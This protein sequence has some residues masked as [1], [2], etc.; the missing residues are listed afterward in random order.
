LTIGI[1]IVLYNPDLS[2]LIESI[3]SL[4]EQDCKIYL[5]DNNSEINSFEKIRNEFKEKRNNINYTYL[6][7][8]Y[9]IAFAMNRIFDYFLND[10]EVEWVMTLDQD[11][12]CPNNICEQYTS[13]I[14][15][16][17]VGIICPII[18]NR[19]LNNTVSKSEVGYTYVNQCISSASLINKNVWNKVGGF[20]ELMFI[21]FVDFDFCFSIREYGYRIVR[22]NNVVLSHQLGNLSQKKFFNV[23]INVTN[24]NA[25]RRFYYARN[26]IYC[27]R[28]H[29]EMF[30]YSKFLNK[31]I[32]VYLKVILFENNKL[33]KLHSLNMGL[34]KGRFMSISIKNK[35]EMLK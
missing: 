19:S 32:K 6:D 29:K 8:N 17:D 33:S 7:K 27:H 16:K 1:G 23:N 3:K 31:I 2:V 5:V 26:A 14:D 18:N 24:H 35:K 22:C 30:S 34:L 13:L 4:I 15:K 25:I 12:I 11:S 28:K 9:G 21:D 10:N 20:D